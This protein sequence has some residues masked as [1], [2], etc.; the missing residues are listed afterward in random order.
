MRKVQSFIFA[1][2]FFAVALPA[3]AQRD[4]ISEREYNSYLAKALES[5]SAH[6]RLVFTE[7][8]FYSGKQVTG[9]RNIESHFVG[10]EAKRIDVK[11]EF[12]GIQA[13]NDAIRIGDQYFCRE[14]NKEWKRASKDCSKDV[15]MAIPD[16][17]YEYFV[18]PDPND[19]TRKIFTRRASFGDESSEERNAVRMK[20][21]EIKFVT[22]WTGIITEYVETRRGGVEP[23][24]WTSIQ[25]T[26]YD[27][28]PKDRK[29][30]DP[31]KGH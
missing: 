30:T 3:Y 11:S 20:S 8:T 27:Y 9:K 6:D 19:G 10:K 24:T 7:E 15:T 28:E 18:E 4:A 16:G 1:L 31:I 25:S 14:G 21:I 13:S 5:A 22:D 12:N 29:I 2:A 26:K 17:E 23:N